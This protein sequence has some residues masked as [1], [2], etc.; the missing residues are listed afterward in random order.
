MPMTYRHES[1][2]AQGTMKCSCEPRNGMLA[3]TPVSQ[4][5][6]RRYNV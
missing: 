1:V 4:W 6:L 5:S 2:L 3:R